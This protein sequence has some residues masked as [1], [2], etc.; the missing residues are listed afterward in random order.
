[1]AAALAAAALA[2][3]VGVADGGAGAAR[4]AA[5]TVPLDEITNAPRLT[6]SGFDPMM[7]VHAVN[8]LQPEG[9]EHALSAL[10]LFLDV[11]RAK[12]LEDEGVFLILRALF[13][14]P[15]GTKAFPRMMVGA[16]DWEPAAADA[17]RLPRFPLAIESD[18]P[19]FL[20]NGY[21]LAGK[22]ENPRVHLEWCARNG[23]LRATTL[24]PPDDPW[25][26]VDALVAR[27]P[28]LTGKGHEHARALVRLQALRA[29]DRVRHGKV[30]DDE[31][32]L[33]DAA[34]DA[35]WAEIEKELIARKITWSPGEARYVAP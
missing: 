26:A 23:V 14:L 8:R 32:R 1:M 24:R 31:R 13:E 29:I 30:A 5:D 34:G 19:L 21:T 6:G 17:A 16:P 3:G 12:G 11:A 10:R 35:A 18:L 7:L 27:T 2:I 4:A 22:A 25:A 28:E 9:K 33:Y 20:V 15:P